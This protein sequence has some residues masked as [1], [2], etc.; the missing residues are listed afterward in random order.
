AW[1]MPRHAPLRSHRPLPL[2]RSNRGPRHRKEPHH[3]ARRPSGSP[4]RPTLARA[5]PVDL[6][7]LFRRGRALLGGGRVAAAVCLVALDTLFSIPRH[8]FDIAPL[9]A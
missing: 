8:G 7:R 6:A 3:E 2:D 5:D 4:G 1:S 9:L